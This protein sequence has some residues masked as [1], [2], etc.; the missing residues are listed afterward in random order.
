MPSQLTRGI[1]IG[2]LVFIGSIF[3]LSTIGLGGFT[4]WLMLILAGYLIFFS[5][6]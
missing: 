4:F 3:I 6:K 1:G 2:I 5:K